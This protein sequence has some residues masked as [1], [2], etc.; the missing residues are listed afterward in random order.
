VAT[1]IE[2]MKKH[3]LIVGHDFSISND[4][5]R[6]VYTDYFPGIWAISSQKQTL[7][8]A[9][10]LL[11]EGNEIS[12]TDYD[13]PK[14]HA[15]A[16]KFIKALGLKQPLYPE[17]KPLQQMLVANGKPA[18]LAQLKRYLIVGRKLRVINYDSAGK[19]IGERDTSVIGTQTGAVIVERNGGKSWMEYG[20]AEGLTFDEHGATCHI[21]DNNGYRPSVRIEYKD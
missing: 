11:T 20:K 16:N 4:T 19:R 12:V 18:S 17:P 9:R 2:N 7:E 14:Y 13:Q 21:L 10:K 8:Y 6:D 1:L 3:T 5:D 15:L